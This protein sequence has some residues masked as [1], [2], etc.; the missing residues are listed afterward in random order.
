MSVD[1]PV[2]TLRELEALRQALEH[3][4]TKLQLRHGWHVADSAYLRHGALLS[5][6]LMGSE[7]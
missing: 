2:T 4:R 5:A 1:Y 3:W 7:V 6:A